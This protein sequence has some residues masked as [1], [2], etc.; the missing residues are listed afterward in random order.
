MSIFKRLIYI[1]F[2]LFLVFTLNYSSYTYAN[3]L[4]SAISFGG[5]SSLSLTSKI[6]TSL[7]KS[8]P[9]IE[10]YT[11]VIQVNKL[12]TEYGKELA[13]ED[14]NTKENLRKTYKSAFDLYNY[15]TEYYNYMGVLNSKEFEK[16]I[17]PA[18]KVT[19]KQLDF[20]SST[21][22]DLYLK[23]SSV[24]SKVKS[25]YGQVVDGLLVGL[26]DAKTNL[27]DYLEELK[28]TNVRLQTDTNTINK[29]LDIEK[30][31][32]KEL[33]KKYSVTGTFDD[34]K[35]NEKEISKM[36]YSDLYY[37]FDTMQER[38]EFLH[39][40]ARYY[41][42]SNDLRLK[43]FPITFVHFDFSSVSDSQCSE[44]NNALSIIY[45]AYYDYGIRLNYKDVNYLMQVYSTGVLSNY[46][47][48][49][50]PNSD[51]NKRFAHVP[52]IHSNVYY[53][54]SL[55]FD[56]SKEETKNDFVVLSSPLFVPTNF[57]SV[58]ITPF[59][60]MDDIRHYYEN[61]INSKLQ[62]ENRP[63]NYVMKLGDFSTL[64]PLTKEL[65]VTLPKTGDIPVV[66]TTDLP[67]ANDSTLPTDKD[68]SEEEKK[69]NL[70]VLPGISIP[71]LQ[72]KENIQDF[73]KSLVIPDE[74]FLKDYV[75]DLN[76]KIKNPAKPEKIE[77]FF[78]KLKGGNDSFQFP[79]FYLTL[80][81]K[82]FKFIDMSVVNNNLPYFHKYTDWFF[83]LIFF[84][85][86]LNQFSKLLTGTTL[87]NNSQGRSVLDFVRQNDDYS[88][89]D[90][91]K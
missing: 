29:L 23:T 91:V 40:I 8:F 86:N 56:L 82:T 87:F 20:L 46:F 24:A 38:Q 19:K 32:N 30:S 78:N 1:I 42:G 65:V 31:N 76:S 48:E 26:N 88:K 77:D 22:R 73:V 55:G 53:I 17:Q 69:D 16:R 61:Y 35:I 63:V 72:T 10:G 37:T 41:V 51:I 64:Q 3:S 27:N 39:S 75:N 50:Y 7:S 80:F 84:L 14:Y 68:V 83:W 33:S 71:G 58:V 36:R 66:N 59:N 89:N 81:G 45:S 85:Y 79:D 4:G 60:N 28:K 15:N 43:H 21:L 90:T 57:F 47:L 9:T 25:K 62:Q 67:I 13:E 44:M 52:Y 34:T 5:S 74:N 2:S 12:V 6:A 11:L 18:V 54:P 70:G 49:R